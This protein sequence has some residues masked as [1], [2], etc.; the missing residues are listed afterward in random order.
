MF[1]DWN[2]APG[3][4]FTETMLAALRGFTGCVPE[5]REGGYALG[6]GAMQPSEIRGSAAM[7]E[8]YEMGA[9]FEKNGSIKNTPEPASILEA[10]SGVRFLTVFSGLERCQ[11]AAASRSVR[12]RNRRAG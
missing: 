1:T 6:V 2:G 4:A 9:A 11:D 12:W 3:A 8:A 5:S 10:G 7:T